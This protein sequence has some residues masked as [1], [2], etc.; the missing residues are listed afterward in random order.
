AKF[1]F[2]HL[3]RFVEGNALGVVLFGPLPTFLDD[4]RYREP[5]ILFVT[6]ERHAI[7]DK[8]YH[9][10]DLAIEVGSPDERS[11]VRDNVEKRQLYAAATIPEYWIVD[12]QEEK[13]TV[14]ALH[15]EAYVEHCVA[16]PGDVAKS[17]LLEGFEVD[18]AAVFSAGKRR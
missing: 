5:D 13:I 11:K 17:R 1:L 14:L 2:K 9:G 8:Y 3:D 16:K 15:G 12:P 7:S 4:D 10:A 18:A 6:G